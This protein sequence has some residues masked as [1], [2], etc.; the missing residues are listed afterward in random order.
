[1]AAFAD[2]S[3]DVNPIHAD[4]SSS[5]RRSFDAPVVYG[6]LG[7]MEALG[8]V[9][10]R[11]GQVLHSLDATFSH[12]MLVGNS[13]QVAVCEQGDLAATAAINDSDMCMCSVKA[14]YIG[15][16]SSEVRVREGSSR[17]EEPVMLNRS[18]IESLEVVTGQYGGRTD[19]TRWLERRFH[20]ARHG[21][22]GYALH[23][24]L[25]ISYV[26]G[27]RLPGVGG[28]LSRLQMFLPAIDEDCAPPSISEPL[29]YT[30]LVTD[31]N[32]DLGEVT[33]CGTINQCGRRV[34]MFT[35]EVNLSGRA[36][37]HNYQ[38]AERRLGV[39]GDLEGRVA[40]VV[41]ASRGL[42][43]ALAQG[44]ASQGCYVYACSR[45]G[46]GQEG[47]PTWNGSVEHVRGECGDPEF[48]RA[49]LERIIK[50]HGGMDFLLCCAAPKIGAIGFGIPSMS[51]FN[52]FIGQ[53]IELITVPTAAFIGVLDNKEGGYL[54]VSSSA[55]D[56]MPR[57]WGHYVAA[58]AA[59]E[60]I[61]VWASKRFANVETVIARVPRMGR[62]WDGAT[63]RDDLHAPE[64]VAARLVSRLLTRQS[65]GIHIMEW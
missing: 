27:M 22:G 52:Q 49:L 33:V 34:V 30:A 51:R 58:K 24:L 4:E 36:H 59:G 55:L 48:C 41:G 35:C 57:E 45:T 39:S 61:A 20:L 13:Y 43:A 44:M 31:F 8:A 3:G 63:G 29:S 12:P 15:G 9:D 23:G 19:S 10:I 64:E 26:I 21:V 53:S 17:L 37:T 60:A 38:C 16:V 56:T 54:L 18:A 32:P 40:V 25:C 5:S 28:M 62:G 42:G 7:I 14:S 1:M 47:A 2:A 11:A 50:R 65:A 46:G 6:V